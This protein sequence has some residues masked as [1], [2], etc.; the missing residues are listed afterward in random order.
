MSERVI[1]ELRER[2]AELEAELACSVARERQRER[3]L[4]AVSHELE[5]QVLRGSATEERAATAEA[6]FAEAR[7]DLDWLRRHTDATTAA[8]IEAREAIAALRRHYG[9]DPPQPADQAPG[10]DGAPPEPASAAGSEP[11]EGP[12]PTPG[13]EGAPVEPDGAGEATDPAG[14]LA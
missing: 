5:L 3:E 8:F 7:A 6:R 11:V 2:L 12:E 4:A 14:R 13:A 1:W 9:V 10:A